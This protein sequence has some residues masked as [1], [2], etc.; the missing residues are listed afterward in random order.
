MADPRL[1]YWHT[2]KRVLQYLKGTTTLGLKYGPNVEQHK[3]SYGGL[4]LVGYADSDYIGD[5]E[6]RRSM[7]GYVYCLNGAAVSWSSKRA[8][9]VA[10]FSTEA[11]YVA[12]S[13]VSKQA[14]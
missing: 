3:A 6:S 7:M 14:I 1:G 2:A 13:N 4:D 12:W 11:E 10:V 5:T 9:T 8:K